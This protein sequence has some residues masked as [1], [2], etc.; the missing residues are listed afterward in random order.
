MNGSLSRRDFLTTAS[1]AAVVTA[2]PATAADNRPEAAAPRAATATQTIRLQRPT[3]PVLRRGEVAVV[4]GGLAGVSAALALAQAGRKVV[5]VE[6]RTYL[7]RELTA[8]LRPW[9]AGS[10]PLPPVLQA[11]L[12]APAAASEAGEIPLHMD[13]VKLALEDLL[14]AAGVELLYASFPIGVVTVG[15]AV[16]G[17]IIG[18]KSGRQVVACQ[19][20]V[21]T[22]ETAVVARVAGAVFEAVTP[23][24]AEFRRTIEFDGV[25]PL[26]ETT[27]P[28]PNHLDL[29]GNQV[30]LHRGY[31]GADHV[32]VECVLSLPLEG[33]EPED[34]MRR[35]SAARRRLMQ[36]AAY[37]TGAVPAFQQAYLA[38]TSY[39]LSGPASAR[40]QGPPPA[41]AQALPSLRMPGSGA[42]QEWPLAALAGPVKELWCLNEAARR[43]PA[44]LALVGD[45]LFACRVGE[46]FA[47]CAVAHWA[48][49]ASGATGADA[50][51]PPAEPPD[52]AL[53]V[54]EP[55][56][57]Q[58]GRRYDPCAVA[59][60]DVPVLRQVDVL[61]VGG[62]TSGAT[63]AITAAREGVTTCVLEMNPGLGG[64]ATL[65][66]V[67]SYW[68]GRRV[69]FPARV[70]KLVQ[71]VQERIH[72]RPAGS[73]WNIEAKMFALLEEAERA[74]AAVLLPAVV[75]GTLVE[76]GGH[77][78]GVVAAT[79]YG[80][81][82][83]LAR[84]V[85][86]ATGD[87][88]V[89][90]FA[91]AECVTGSAMDHISMWYVLAQ[92]GRPG[93]N[94]N[95]FTSQLDVSNIED[96]QRALLA[97]RRRGGH[98]HDHG[99]YLA[100]RESRHVRAETVLTVTDA[101]RQRAWPDVVNIHYSNHDVKGKTTSQWLQAGLIPPNLETEIP[102]RVLLPQGLEN[103]LLAGK[104]FSTNHDGLVGLRMQADLENLGGVVGL[105]AAQAVKAGT[106]PRRIDVAQLQQ[107][108]VQEGVLPPTVLTRELKPRRY[109]DDELAA[110]V[111]ALVAD[112][113]LLAYQ[114]MQMFDV[115][116]GVIPFVEVCTAGP[117]IVPCLEAA[118]PSA[119]PDRQIVLAQALALLGSPAGV[120][121]LVAE[122]ERLLTGDKVPARKTRI[123]HAGLP[124][125][126]GAAPEVV[127][128]L[129]SLGM[130]RDR[131]SLRLWQRVADLLQPRE[132]HFRDALLGTFCYVD[133]VCY[134]A[135]R[136][137]DPAAIPILEK[138]HRAPALSGLVSRTGFQPDFVTERRALLEVALGKALARCGSPQGFA[139]LIA[140]LDD[141]RAL[142]AEQAHANLVRI[143]GCDH[144]KDAAA[145]AAWLQA[146]KATL[147]P[148]PL[149]E[150]LDNVYGREILVA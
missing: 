73:K 13:R 51:S 3:L 96:C 44:E 120:P 150:D 43:E 80:L 100:T 57:P 19:L 79:R 9:L 71:Q 147:S 35:E 39:E 81:R 58:A 34:A 99:V 134:G 67:D 29:V 136:L 105:A 128:L 121:V 4:G 50:A 52:G 14:L 68:F 131:R 46:A 31:R 91:G 84:V 1:G 38:A 94:T 59:P 86:D 36:L 137:A 127:Y 78:R 108:L 118:L 16:T 110:L 106:T 77:V 107:R 148:C 40:L 135:E 116:R 25:A 12:S 61:V 30:T 23:G 10:G 72:H 129:Y 111:E 60:A 49:M 119:A 89:A 24:S 138:L 88:D 32:L 45:P 54:R 123:L 125:D 26:A 69:G 18:N 33:F 133:A 87:G 74:G 104:A 76:A 92:F 56:G 146:A 130:A 144:G 70:T 85:I 149:T 28:V 101:L 48:G 115:F 122:A 42:K 143:S 66:G 47:Q 103:L 62:G 114:D 97:G 5:L 21:D 7:G 15:D 117:R 132:E 37:L 17:L 82:A 90:A 41:W 63:A 139:V 27:I 64:T 55:A 140:Y 95:S 113:P 98:C 124:P 93:R 2:W 8:T 102:Y 83:V 112:K 109:R 65:A 126:Q 75:V 145:W 142:L 53:A 22:T 6:P 11:C 20:I 141:S